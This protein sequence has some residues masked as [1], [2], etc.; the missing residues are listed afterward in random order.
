MKY[1]LCLYSINKRLKLIRNILNDKQGIR[2][3]FEKHKT[4]DHGR[5]TD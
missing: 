3:I 5:K 2:E 4:V 1:E